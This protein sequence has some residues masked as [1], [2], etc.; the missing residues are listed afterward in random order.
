MN[1]PV[2]PRR[3]I[4]LAIIELRLSGHTRMAESLLDADAA[5]AQ[6]L[7]AANT[8]AA[9]SSSDTHVQVRTTDIAQLRAALRLAGGG[10]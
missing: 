9:H 8:V 10:A 3:V 5:I 2:D 6:L 7:S 1:T 4:T